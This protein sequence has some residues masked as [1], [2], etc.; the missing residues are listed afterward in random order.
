MYS[1]KGKPGC[2]FTATA[3][4]TANTYKV[5]LDPNGGAELA[6]VITVT[7]GSTYGN[8]STISRSG[9]KFVGWYLH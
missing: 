1:S 9:Y 8:L 2:S 4:W 7:Y 3:N 5:A 6:Q